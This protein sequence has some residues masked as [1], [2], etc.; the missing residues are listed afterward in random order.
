MTTPVLVT[1][2]AGF[3]GFHTAQTLMERGIPVIGID[4]F[5]PY[6]DPM[7][8]EAR[9]TVLELSRQ[10]FTGICLDLSGKD[11]VH[12]LFERYRPEIVIHLAAQPG[13]RQS[14]ERPRPY[15]AANV[16]GFFN[17]LEACRHFPV[18]HLVY[19]SSSSVYGLNTTMPFSEDAPVSR[20]SSLYA[21]TKIADEAMAHAYSH[22]YGIPASGLRFFTVYG[23]WGRPDMAVYAFTDAI[24][25]DQPIKVS[26][27]G[28][29]WRDFTYVSDIVEGILRLVDKPPAAGDGAAPHTVYNIGNDQPEELNRLIALI[30]GEVGKTAQRIDVPLPPGDI[31]KTWADIRKLKQAVGFSPATSLEDGV[32]QFVAWYKGYTGD[33][34]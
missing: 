2:A 3:I 25:R 11:S 18:R 13:V 4:S 28:K 23:P 29:V 8:K 15:L 6:Y 34:R 20:P 19:A 12:D 26:A 21:A 32:R 27:G 1:G 33:I 10:L 22:L 5:A 16:S 9:W 14:I 24:V 17:V 31:V 7:L 30:E